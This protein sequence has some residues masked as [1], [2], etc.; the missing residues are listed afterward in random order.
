MEPYSDSIYDARA[1]KIKVSGP[2]AM[3][4]VPMQRFVNLYS[5]ADGFEAGTIFKDLDLPFLGGSGR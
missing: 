2:L 5:A 1:A 4:Y 3:A